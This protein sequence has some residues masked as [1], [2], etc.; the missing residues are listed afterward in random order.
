LRALTGRRNSVW[1]AVMGVLMLA[2]TVG[3]VLGARA[4]AS[5]EAAKAR[6]AFRSASIEIA[7]NLRMAI[8][9]EEDLVISASAFVTTNPA[10][11]PAEFDRW[12]ESVHALQRYPELQNIGLLAYVPAAE[13]GA[14]EARIAADPVRALGPGSANPRGR[15]AILPVGRRPYYCLAV[16]GLARSSA[17][18]LPAGLDYCALAPQLV[19]DRSAGM[20]AY[21]PFAKGAATLLGVE[22]PVYRGG[23]VPATVA[24]RERAFIGWLGELITPNVLLQRA[25][26]GHPGIAVALR[27]R[28]RFSHV[29]LTDGT[30]PAHAQSTRLQLR[31]GSRALADVDAGWTVQTYGAPV[32]SGVFGNFHA[33][34]LL[35]GGCLLSLLFG[36]LV[37]VLGTGRTRARALVQEKTR[38]LYHQALHDTLTGLPNRALVL[39]RAEQMLARTARHPGALT[40]ALFID[41]DSFKRVNDNLGHAAGDELLRVVGERLQRVVRRQDTV[42]R[43]GGDEFV[44]LVEPADQATLGALADRLTEILREPVELGAGRQ[45]S[46]LTASIG[47]AVGRYTSPDALLRDADLAL[48]A[49]KAAGKD[50]YVLFDAAM[51]NGVGDRLELETELGEALRKGQLFLLYQPIYELVSGRVTGVEALV[52]W[53]HPRK[54]VVSPERFIPVAEESGLIVPIG[55]WVLE[56][57][58]HQVAAWGARGLDVGVSV[59]VSASQ[60]SRR[61]F[62]EDVQRAV[63]ESQIPPS[64]LTLEI[65]ETT[66]MR[67]V[68]A[69]CGHLE[70]IR[71]SGVGIAIDDFGTGYASISTLQRVPVDILKVDTSFVAALD[72][73]D[74]DRSEQTR[75]LLKAILD[76]G[77]ALSLTVIAEG[78]EHQ[79][80]A[81]ALLEMG[82]EIGQGYLMAMP[83][84][85]RSIEH[86]LEAGAPQRAAGST[87]PA[88]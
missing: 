51:Y 85:A 78:I 76:V 4:V 14:F 61:E 16:A 18:Y 28:S 62:V 48:Y 60:L 54:G 9:H 1:A 64:R 7:T 81:R 17:T 5:S 80:Q 13:L 27:Y 25:L 66:L 35:I 49:A 77:H 83:D 40:G 36:L 47:V 44:V 75:K 23:V 10:M 3:A 67:N 63:E 19:L 59:N 45:I 22:T 11:S 86:L 84:R 72:D 87:V 37:F 31:A 38:E 29:A 2:G 8:Q 43:L 82:C 55:R 65:T 34:T 6:L 30:V 15:L 70:A 68:P 52:R 56:E 41:I 58:C 21:A 42:G 39:D 20:T 88:E 79:S 24:G 12:S 69:A 26:Y 46:S 32:A 71:A 50:R 33:L 53:Q 73:A 74:R 57:A